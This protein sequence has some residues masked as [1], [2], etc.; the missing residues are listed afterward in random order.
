MP[1][2]LDPSNAADRIPRKIF[3]GLFIANMSA[4]L[5]L[6]ILLP[7]LSPYAKEL[8]ASGFLLGLVFAGYAIGRGLCSPV[9]GQVSDKYGR[10]N[11]MLVG[12]FLYGVLPIGYILSSSVLVLGILWFCQGIASAMVSP[13]AQSYIGDITPPGKEGRVMNLFYIGQFGGVAIGP[14]IGG[15]LADNF[16]FDAPFY[17]MMGA[18]FLGFFLVLFVIPEIKSA[19]KKSQMGFR[20]SFKAVLGDAKIKGVLYYLVGRGFYRWGFN[21]FFPIYVIALAGLSKSQV[22]VLVSGYMV[23]GTLLQYPCGHLADRFP[24]NRA[25]LV[26]IGGGLAATF[27]FL[28]PLFKSMFWLVILV[29]LMGAISALPRAT[30]VAIR[31]ERGRKFGMGAVTGVYMTGVSAGQVF[32]PIGFGAITDLLSIPASFYIGGLSGLITTGLAYWYLRFRS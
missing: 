8:G 25:E 7:L 15:F 17:F 28:V 9:F 20:K 26:A 19:R 13:I 2:H 12:L 18:A 32:G 16:S 1:K 31:T 6:G 3:I 30:T 5:G 23:A 29:I 10:K 4:M 11:M 21:S 22:G 14:F 27:M 24:K